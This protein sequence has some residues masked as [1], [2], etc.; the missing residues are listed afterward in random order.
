MDQT[1]SSSP[2]RRQPR[3]ARSQYGFAVFVLAVCSN[4]LLGVGLVDMM[5]PAGALDYLKIALLVV[6][7]AIVT[8]TVNRVAIE[9]GAR[10][11]VVGYKGFGLASVAAM[12]FVGTG[13]ATATFAGLTRG[14]VDKLTL[15][16]HGRVLSERIAHSSR[17]TPA[18]AASA[19]VVRSIAADLAAK[20]DCERRESCVSGRAAGGRGPVARHLQMVAARGIAIAGE[21]DTGARG[22]SDAM[23]RSGALVADYV[24]AATDGS[25]ATDKRVRLQT[26]DAQIRES[27]F[28]RAAGA[29]ASLAEAYLSELRASVAIPGQPDASR[30][31]ALLLQAHA[32]GLKRALAPAS[33]NDQA[34]PAFPPPAGTLD[35]LL[36]A[37]RF[38]PILVLALVVDAVLP[39]L[40]WLS[41]VATKDWIRNGGM[42]PA[43]RPPSDDE[44]ETDAILVHPRRTLHPAFDPEA[45]F[46]SLAPSRRDRAYHDERGG[47][48]AG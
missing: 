19:P 41:A 40:L 13:L 10:L 1:F 30:A 5:Q 33:T 12:A 21:L 15:E 32:D 45:Y 38:W 11:F 29:P 31:V 7:G 43:A 18:L 24:K 4:A 8:V 28:G 47:R 34:L 23:R 14:D 39:L 36:H 25:S 44:R 20:A 35:T 27:F 22:V 46:P 37:A 3:A 6:A 48:D 17:D 26:L 42:A 9:R 2:H 16:A